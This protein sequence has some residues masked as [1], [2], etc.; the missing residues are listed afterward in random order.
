MARKQSI[1][2]AYRKLTGYLKRH[3]GPCCYYQNDLKKK[4]SP[5]DWG[6]LRQ[7]IFDAWD[8]AGQGVICQNCGSRPASE[9]HHGIVGRKK[10]YTVLDRKENLVPLCHQCNFSRVLDNY[11]GRQKCWNMMI[12]K[13]G[14]SVMDEWLILVN[15]QFTFPPFEPK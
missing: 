1:C 7:E 6:R 11:Q 9:L 10:G 12:D 2:T 4:L 5:N 8:K 3:A 14:Q 15:L 13:W